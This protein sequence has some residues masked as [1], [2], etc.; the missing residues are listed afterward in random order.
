METPMPPDN[1]TGS[2]PH[3]VLPDPKVCRARGWIASYALC[4]V[5]N[6][7][8]CNYGIS[9][10]TGYFCTHPEREKIVAETKAAGKKSAST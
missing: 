5:D 7:S 10:K 2:T 8:I 4:L 6:P 1:E 3:R 9:F